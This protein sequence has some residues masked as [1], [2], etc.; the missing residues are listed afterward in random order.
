MHV[1]RDS[2]INITF[3]SL[4]CLYGVEITRLV[5]LEREFYSPQL[6]ELY[7][8]LKRITYTSSVYLHKLIFFHYNQLVSP[9][10]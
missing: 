3:R 9:I 10:K 8:E 1:T 6:K 7:T 5:T 2:Q 4:K